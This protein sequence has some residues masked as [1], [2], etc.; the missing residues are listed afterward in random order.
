MNQFISGLSQNKV[1]NK[2]WL[3]VLYTILITIELLFTMTL[4]RDF[5]HCAYTCEILLDSSEPAVLSSMLGV[6]EAVFD[7]YLSLQSL[8]ITEKRAGSLKSWNI[9]LLSTLSINNLLLVVK[10]KVH[11]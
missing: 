11:F 6:D 2:S 9:Y 8:S 3:T 4:F 7:T 1:T 10:F 5:Q